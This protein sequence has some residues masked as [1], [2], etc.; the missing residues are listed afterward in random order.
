MQVIRW[1]VCH[2]CLF[3]K[4]LFASDHSHPTSSFLITTVSVMSV[5]HLDK[6][7]LTS[8]NI[9]S[10]LQHLE[11][12]GAAGAEEALHLVISN[13]TVKACGLLN[14]QKRSKQSIEVTD[15]FFRSIN[16]SVC[17]LFFFCLWSHLF[18]QIAEENCIFTVLWYCILLNREKKQWL[19]KE[20]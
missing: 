16:T 11:R 6:R 19:R 14:M 5:P 18:L 3:H 10:D 20:K 7:R 1:T 9:S 8:R 13:I 17:Y 4:C 15:V 12:Q 2:N